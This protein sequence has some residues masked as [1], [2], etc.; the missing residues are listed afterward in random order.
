LTQQWTLDDEGSCIVKFSI[1]QDLSFSS[2]KQDLSVLLN[3][4]IDKCAPISDDQ[5]VVF[6]RIA[7][8]TMAL[9]LADPMIEDIFARYNCSNVYRRIAQR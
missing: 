1:T 3:S 7:H 6:P 8:Y 2:S 4:C 9:R 5:W